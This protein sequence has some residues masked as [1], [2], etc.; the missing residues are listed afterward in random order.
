MSLELVGQFINGTPWADPPAMLS[1]I[2]RIY[3][4]HVSG[5]TPE[6]RR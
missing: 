5:E 3:D 1:E 4:A 6:S 2:L